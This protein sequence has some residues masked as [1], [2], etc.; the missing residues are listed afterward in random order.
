MKFNLIL[1]SAAMAAALMLNSCSEPAATPAPV[2]DNTPALMKGDQS[3]TV[4]LA[5]SNVHWKGDMLGIYS[6]DGN[7][8]L[9]AANV[10]LKD[11]KVV[12]GNFTVDMA[13]IE[14]LDNGY[15]DADKSKAN[16]IGHLSSA[17]F[18]DIANN[19]TSTFTI[20]GGNGTTATGSLS[21]RG[22]SN[23]ETVTDLVLTPEGDGVK[24]TG[25][26]KFDRKKYDVS[27]DMPVGDKV[28]SN[29]I[30][31]DITLVAKK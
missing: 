24:V 19:P 18:F 4:D 25:K 20:T 15:D 7:I 26:L 3:L 23:P 27:F 28:L 13:S 9:T 17:A 10:M 2:A 1:A 22:K 6:H 5:A 21:L 14:P 12:G 30:T 8:K 11:G 31:L 29:D 16:L